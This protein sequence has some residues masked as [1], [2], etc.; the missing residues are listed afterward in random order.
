ME[1]DSVFGIFAR[2]LIAKSGKSDDQITLIEN[3]GYSKLNH[4]PRT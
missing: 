3:N 1:D 2:D 4:N